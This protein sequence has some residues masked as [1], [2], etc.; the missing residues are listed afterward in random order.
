MDKDTID[1]AKSIPTFYA[2]QSIF[3]TGATG[4]LGKVLIEK[5][6]RCCPNI[7]EIFILMRPKKGQSLNERVEKM[8]NLPLYDKLREEQP[9]NIRKLIAIS[10][11]ISQ[12]NLGLSAVD[13][14]I[15]IER[16]T[17]IIHN[18]ANVKFNDSLKYA[19]LTNIRST[20]DICILAENVKNLKALVYVSTAFAHLE[21]PFIKEKVYPPVTDWRK[22]IKVAESLDEHTLNVFAHKCL[23]N[24]P[25]TYIFSKKLAEN[26]IQ[27]YSAALPCAIVR[28]SMVVGSLK[29]P[30][31]GW[32][33]NFNGPIGL[34]CFGST[35]LLRLVYGNNH[36]PQNNVP[37]DTVI[38]TIILVI[39]KLG[40]TL[41]PES[42][43]FVVNCTFPDENNISL[44]ELITRGSK[45]LREI[46]FEKCFWTFHPF[47][48]ESVIMHYILTILFHIIP[49]IILDSVLKL[50]GR[51][52]MIL[53]L[54]R[55]AYVVN[56]VL[57]HFACNKWK[58]DDTNSKYLMSLIPPDNREMFSI[59]LSDVDMT[60]YMRIGTI[61][62][63]KYLLHEDMNRLDA[64]K[65]RQKRVYLFVTTFK[66]IIAIAM[67]WMIYKWMLLE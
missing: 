30:I 53:K 61:G 3:L 17:I 41:T 24:S 67:L 34:L 8:L 45:I 22:F 66:T 32:I 54:Q 19:I 55:K 63:K 9:S 50:S 43:C 56:R 4:F 12:E 20:R 10:G 35:G 1:A 6:L 39:W 23:D 59:D 64:A 40:L 48:I 42:T 14:Q 11:D 7:G 44:Q 25:N 18:A 33:D 36:I 58:F 37:V 28:P 38:N 65:A 13:R 51:Q 31:P 60:K 46:P 62:G 57:G 26:I 21:N 16:V 49:A 52:P 2:G 15:L 29:D 27:E 47:I 5:I